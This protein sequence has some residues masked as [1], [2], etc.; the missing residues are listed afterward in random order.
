MGYIDK[1]TNSKCTK[2]LG[3]GIDIK[4]NNIII[5]NHIGIGFIQI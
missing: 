2:Y 3:L 5:Y 1:S 4:Y